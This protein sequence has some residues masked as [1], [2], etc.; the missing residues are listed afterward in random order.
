MQYRTLGKS[1]V[2]V[3]ALGFGCMRLPVVDGNMARIDK[4]ATTALLQKALA[5]GVTYVDTAYVYHEG[6]S[7]SVVG[8]IIHELGVRSQIMLA[9]KM[10]V[11]DIKSRADMERIFDE[12]C[13]KLRT[14]YIDMYLLHTLNKTYWPQVRDAGVL[15]FLAD[16]Q[17]QGRI[18]HSGFS[19]HD[20]IDVF[21]EIV[22]AH[23][24]ECCQIQYNYL[25]EE[26]QAGTEGLHYAAARGMG[27][28]IMEPLRG[29]NLAQNPP[30]DIQKVWDATP[31]TRSPADWALRWLLN[32]P[33]VSIILSGMNA[34]PQV[35]ENARVC[36]EHLPNAFTPA[37]EQAVATVAELYSTR[38][39]VPCTGCRYCMPCPSG[40]N[41]PAIFNIYNQYGLFKNRQW[42]AGMYNFA[43]AATSECATNCIECGQCEESCP[44]HI[45]IIEKLKE[46]HTALAACRMP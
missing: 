32:K 6:H 36:A 45:A 43:L 2:K 46:A 33:E 26:L 37:E 5:L 44:Q 40:V 21:K 27:V 19:F 12:Q 1:G 25:D 9:T 17:T 31:F 39:Q 34:M 29:G 8:D 14:D 18:R 3:S 35:E 15:E 24:W 4:P 16:M 7:E 38:F 23:P 20:D 13:R 30:A 10:P 22:D 28:V 41:I 11:W 42:C